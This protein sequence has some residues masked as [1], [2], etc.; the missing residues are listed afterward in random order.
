[1]SVNVF[2]QEF[3]LNRRGFLIWT[4]ILILV[5][6]VYLPFFPFMQSPDYGELLEG[7]PDSLKEAL[8]IR[9]IV[10]E[11]IN[12]YY[13]VLVL[14]YLLL[15][16]AIYAAMLAGRLVAREADLNTADFLFTRPVTRSR[17]MAA[18]AGA[19]LLLMV[20][21]WALLY[22]A[23]VITGTATDP[24]NFDSIRQL[25]VH[26]AG[27]LATLA[28]G[29]IAFAAAPLL[30]QV[31]AATTLGVALGFGFFLVDALS[32]TTEKLHFLRYFTVYYYAGFEDA[33]AGKPFYPGMLFLLLVFLLGTA[34]GF[35][36]LHRKE[37]TG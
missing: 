18:K 23:A 3:R 6:V 24:G 4:A 10:F 25:W 2:R 37:Y 32:K 17:I 22:A 27:L 19:F 12:Y 1:M 16:A 14:Q 7:F 13:A 33:A 11:E 9:N 26:L 5:L 36:L 21:L 15:L 29:G 31:S 35:L 28:A 30:N 34:L 20:L 8:N